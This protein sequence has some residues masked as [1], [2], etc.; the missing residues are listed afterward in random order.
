MELVRDPALPPSTLSI[1]PD[2]RRRWFAAPARGPA[3]T[4]ADLAIDRIALDAAG[5]EVTLAP[6][7]FAERLGGTLRMRMIGDV[8]RRRHRLDTG[9]IAD[10]S[11]PDRRLEIEIG[12]REAGAE[13]S[14]RGRDRRAETTAADDERH[15]PGQI[16][17]ADEVTG[18]E[19]AAIESPRRLI[20]RRGRERIRLGADETQMR[21]GS[22]VAHVGARPDAQRVQPYPHTASPPANMIHPELSLALRPQIRLHPPG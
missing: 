13:V 15:P 14:E 19:S 8:K 22:V 11:Q 5:T 20:A 18:G 7:P 12:D 2:V 3:L 9:A 4:Q 6:G 10:A 16:E 21:S 1:P 17:E